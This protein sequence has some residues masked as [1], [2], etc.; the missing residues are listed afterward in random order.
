MTFVELGYCE[1]TNK[2]IK[3]LG[4]PRRVPINA[5]NNRVNENRASVSRLKMLRVV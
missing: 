4:L 5:R 2:L 3:V 1:A